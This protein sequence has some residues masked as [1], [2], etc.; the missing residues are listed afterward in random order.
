MAISAHLKNFAD[1]IS[2][3]EQVAI[4]SFAEALEVIPRTLAENTG[5]DPI[6]IMAELRKA[7]AGFGVDPINRKVADFRK[8]AVVEPASVKRQAISSAAEAAQ[9]ILRI[10]DVISAK[11]LGGGAPGAGGPGGMG[12]D[13]DFD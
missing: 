3:R 1:T 12:G 9:M 11:D 5:L 7:G 2:G 6:D 10:D 13:E 4:K 8:L